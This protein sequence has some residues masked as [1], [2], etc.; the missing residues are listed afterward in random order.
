[1]D[2][3]Y[4]SLSSSPRLKKHL[5]QLR[6]T[7]KGLYTSG[8]DLPSLLE[9]PFIAIVGTRKPTSYGKQV[10]ISLTSALC[11][12]GLGIV[13]GLAYGI[14]SIAHM[15]ALETGGSTIAVLPSPLE[16]IYPQHHQSL[17]RRITDSGGCVVSEMAAG[18]AVYKSSFIA[19]NRII[20][21]LCSAVLIPEAATRSGSLHTAAFALEAGKP[22]LAVPGAITS[23]LSNGTNQLIASG[24]IVTLSEQDVFEAIGFTPTGKATSAAITN[25]INNM[26]EGASKTILSIMQLGI[27]S[28][29]EVLQRS[30][31]TVA[32]FGAAFVLLEIEGLIT[33]LGNNHWSIKGGIKA[34]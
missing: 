12:A 27:T 25:T 28:Y 15:A 18:Q 9:K 10:T 23:P 21:G 29:E 26:P 31:L 1:M 16:N 2:S 7:V 20:A 17:A 22:I 3:E 34:R 6:P 24:A 14:D 32:D 11:R 33:P 5:H 13:S 4:I 19:R 8:A 30:L